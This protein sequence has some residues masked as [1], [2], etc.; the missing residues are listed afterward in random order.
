MCRS[1]A[2]LKDVLSL[3]LALRGRI[4]IGKFARF[5]VISSSTT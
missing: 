4:I 3:A 2:S 5:S 1:I